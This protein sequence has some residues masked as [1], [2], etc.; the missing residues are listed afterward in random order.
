MNWLKRARKAKGITARE[1]A[2]SAGISLNYVQRIEGNS[3]TLTPELL[4]SFEDY[5]GFT[6]NEFP[7]NYEELIAKAEALIQEKGK[8][9][10]CVLRYGFIDERIVFTGISLDGKGLRTSLECGKW[11]LE[12]QLWALR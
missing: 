8:E 5:L 3:R 9:G 11:L 12:F 4:S 7:F 2:D 6:R 1:L 10:R